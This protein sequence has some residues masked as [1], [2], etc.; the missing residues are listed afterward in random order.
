[1][2][3][4]GGENERTRLKTERRDKEIEKKVN[5]NELGLANQPPPLEPSY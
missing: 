1:M 4:I 2:K 3:E 5:V